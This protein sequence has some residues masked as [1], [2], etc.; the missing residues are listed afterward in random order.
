MSRVGGRPYKGIQI[1]DPMMPWVTSSL[2][3]TISCLGLC[4]AP[5]R[6]ALAFDTRHQRFDVFCP[7]GIAARLLKLTLT[8]PCC[9]RRLV[10]VMCPATLARHV[11]FA[12]RSAMRAVA[13]SCSGRDR[14]PAA[15][16]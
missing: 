13:T 15:R 5:W 8:E 3:P 4:S 16:R 6:R 14:K 7:A 11:G 9:P 10:W 2:D 1:G 12:R